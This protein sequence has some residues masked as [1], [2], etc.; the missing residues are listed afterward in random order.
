MG[1]YRN[2]VIGEGTY[3]IGFLFA[4]LDL[5]RLCTGLLIDTCRIGYRQLR[6][7]VGTKRHIKDNTR[8]LRTVAD[9]LCMVD[10]LIHGRTECIFFAQ[11]THIETVSH[12]DHLHFTVKEFGKECIIGSDH[13]DR[14][15]ALHLCDCAEG[16]FFLYF[17]CMYAHEKLPWSLVNRYCIFCF[18]P[19]FIFV[20]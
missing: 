19:C 6:G 4:P 15:F 13:H 10:H 14:L 11:K 3:D 1:D 18:L 17:W 9:R 7:S 16:Y 20:K 8:Q 5:D 2:T 12:K